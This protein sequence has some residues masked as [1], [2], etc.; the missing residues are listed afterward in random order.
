[1]SDKFG[2]IEQLTSVEDPPTHRFLLLVLVLC[3]L[4]IYR[5]VP[6]A[7]TFDFHFPQIGYIESECMRKLG[8]IHDGDDGDDDDDDDD[9]H[10]QTVNNHKNTKWK[11]RAGTCLRTTPSIAGGSVMTVAYS[12]TGQNT[13]N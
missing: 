4:H 1:M 7:L 11:R 9:D 12:N 8:W 5:K 3:Y 2:S 13:T 10:G 6:C